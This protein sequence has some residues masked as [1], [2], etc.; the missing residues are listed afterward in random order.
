MK[1]PALIKTT[2]S[3]SKLVNRRILD[4]SGVWPLVAEASNKT[5]DSLQ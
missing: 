3:T 4:A 5:I 2:P 1:L